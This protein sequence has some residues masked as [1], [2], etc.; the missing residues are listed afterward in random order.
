MKQQYGAP[1]ASLSK[2]RKARKVP[3]PV[4]ACGGREAALR[5]NTVMLLVLYSFSDPGVIL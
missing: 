2:K 5:I 1:T 3:P 4:I